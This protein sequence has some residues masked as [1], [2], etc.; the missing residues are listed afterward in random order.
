MV[1]PVAVAHSCSSPRGIPLCEQST[2]HHD[3]H[4]GGFLCWS[5]TKNAA[6]NFRECLY[7][8]VLQG[9]YAQEYRGWVKGMFIFTCSS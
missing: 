5:L 8:H 7:V 2:S 4:L 3:A 9:L 6:G 1:G